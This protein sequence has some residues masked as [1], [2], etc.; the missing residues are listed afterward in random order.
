MLAGDCRCAAWNVYILYSM[1]RCTVKRF[2]TEIPRETASRVDHF[3]AWRRIDDG[4]TVGNN[5]HSDFDVSVA[6]VHAEMTLTPH[7][8]AHNEFR[9]Y[10]DLK[11]V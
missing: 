3:A 10:L 5:N 4:R 9:F 1:P 2:R 7:N 8:S 6:A 11:Y